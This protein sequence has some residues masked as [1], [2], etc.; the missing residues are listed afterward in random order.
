MELV[1]VALARVGAFL[2]V[3]G[4]DPR[5][6]ISTMEALKA[7]GER[8]SFTKVP[9]TFGELNFDKGVELFAGK[10]SDINI[11]KITV[12]TNGIAVDTR[13]STD[14]AQKVLQ[15]LLDA[16]KEAFGAVIQ[17]YRRFFLGHIIFRS[18][19]NLSVLNPVLKHIADIVSSVTSQ[20]ASQPLTYEPSLVSVAVDSSRTNFAP[21]PFTIE[22]RAQVPFSE[23][24]YFSGAPLETKEHLEL[25]RQFEDALIKT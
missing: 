7:L 22:R 1:A 16:I 18:N 6:R 14:D 12:Y 2:E 15:D 13:S 8:Y 11:D 4:I 24:L 17:P 9:Q 10:L 21:G 5:G 23:N 20:N 3:Q 25:I 19:M